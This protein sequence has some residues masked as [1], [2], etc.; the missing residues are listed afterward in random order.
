[1]TT[2]AH[3]WERAQR[4]ADRLFRLLRVCPWRAACCPDCNGAKPPRVGTPRSIWQSCQCRPLAAVAGTVSS[5][6]AAPGV[7]YPGR[8]GSNFRAHQHPTRPEIVSPATESGGAP[9]PAQKRSVS[10]PS[11]R[12]VTLGNALNRYESAE[13]GKITARR[14]LAEVCEFVTPPANAMTVIS[15]NCYAGC[16]RCNR[17]YSGTRRA[18]TL[19]RTPFRSPSL[20]RRCRPRCRSRR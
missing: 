11:P 1:M 9:K 18:K 16:R 3:R 2:P 6:R 20:P 12:R 15:T 19:P 5:A 4:S 13:G 14:I 17:R 10:G 8:G 7:S